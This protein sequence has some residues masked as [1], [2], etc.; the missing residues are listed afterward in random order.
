[1]NYFWQR[2]MYPVFTSK[3]HPEQ[4]PNEVYIG[5]FTVVDFEKNLWATKRK[6]DIA[7]NTKEKIIKKTGNSEKDLFP[8]FMEISEFQERI[9]LLRSL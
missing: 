3:Q 7:Y 1:M 5:N 8:V 9:K 2:F 4:K 6:G